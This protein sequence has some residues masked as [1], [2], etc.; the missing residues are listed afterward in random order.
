MGYRL[1]QATY[2]FSDASFDPKGKMGVCAN[3]IVT[4]VITTNGPR[5]LAAPIQVE[6]FTQTNCTKLEIQSVIIALEIM[7]R[8]IIPKDC[9]IFTDCKT[10]IRKRVTTGFQESNLT[11][12]ASY[13]ESVRVL[14]PV[15]KSPGIKG[16]SCQG[17]ETNFCEAGIKASS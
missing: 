17:C 8:G 10:V 13:H 1:R 16:C 9:H 15:E 11:Q 2:I 5:W 6:Y 4:E 14:K 3:L 7:C 12:F